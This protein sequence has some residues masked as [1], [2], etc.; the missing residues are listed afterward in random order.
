MIPPQNNFGM[1][2]LSMT[3]MYVYVHYEHIQTMSM[4]NI[5]PNKTLNKAYIIKCQND[6]LFNKKM[7]VS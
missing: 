1:P 6:I 7:T 2:D 3:Y 4:Y 5:S